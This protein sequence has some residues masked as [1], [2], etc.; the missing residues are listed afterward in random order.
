MRLLGATASHHRAGACD[1]LVGLGLEAPPP[2]GA[3]WRMAREAKPL[4]TT[5]G[6]FF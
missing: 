5:R 3:P 1:T 2:I 6:E 4:P